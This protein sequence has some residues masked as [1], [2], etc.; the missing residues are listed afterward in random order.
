[1]RSASAPIFFPILDFIILSKNL[2]IAQNAHSKLSRA[3]FDVCLVYL[4]ICI[5]AVPAQCQA[6]ITRHNSNSNRGVALAY[7]QEE[8]YSYFE[9]YPPPHLTH[10]KKKEK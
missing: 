3:L 1:M 5:H 4:S 2:S 9:S 7:D 8:L 6:L 10:T